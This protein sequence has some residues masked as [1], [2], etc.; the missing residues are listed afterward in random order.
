MI[1][2]EASAYRPLVH[3]IRFELKYTPHMGQSKKGI[4]TRNYNNQRRDGSRPSSR[5]YS[6]NRP[7]EGRSQYTPRAARPRPNRERLDQA[8]ESGAAPKHADYRSRTPQRQSSQQNWRNSQSSG[9]SSNH[10]SSRTFGNRQD[11]V[12][13]FKG[14]SRSNT[15]NYSPHS[16]SSDPERRT[17]DDQGNGGQRGYAGSPHKKGT[18]ANFRDNRDNEQRSEYRDRS[19]KRDSSQRGSER[20]DHQSREFQRGERFSRNDKQNRRS[21]Q[22][23]TRNPRWQSQQA[24]HRHNSF[25]G[26]SPNADERTPYEGAQF[27]GD[28][29]RFNDSDTQPEERHVTHLPDGRVL[30]GPRPVQRRN[31]R[32]WTDITDETQTLLQP[33]ETKRVSSHKQAQTGA[34]AKTG[35]P[36]S[37]PKSRTHK[38]SAVTREK[39]SRGKQAVTKPR[40]TGPKPSQRGFQ[41]P[42]S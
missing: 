23:D 39:K 18:H 25:R 6:T 21:S 15:G 33:V 40:S 7:G 14:S 2:E 29:E 17:H 34:S 31:A 16:R 3:Y 35:T 8:W 28:Y 9:H 4:M 38:A 24:A 11:N 13:R 10:N 36:K 1:G 26:R 12:Q 37:P 41:W 42:T 19:P 5:S 27:E 30:K 20:F 32:F 22:P